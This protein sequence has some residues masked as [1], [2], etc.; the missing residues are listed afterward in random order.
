MPVARPL[1]S[2]GRGSVRIDLESIQQEKGKEDDMATETA[3]PV[4]KHGKSMMH[5][6]WLDE[7]QSELSR[8]WKHSPLG[9]W[10]APVVGDA[11]RFSPS[12]DVFERDKNIVVKTDLPGMKKDDIEVR[13]EDGDLVICGERNEKEEVDEENYYRMERSFGSFYRRVP[14]PAGVKAEAVHAK[15]D[16][17]VLEVEIPKPVE[18]K[19]AGEKIKVR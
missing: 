2:H 13:L 5:R 1:Q 6:D 8:M 19:P 7:M 15:F 12:V 11:S 18:R 9:R 10:A 16:D 3:V 14:L 17:G 4:K